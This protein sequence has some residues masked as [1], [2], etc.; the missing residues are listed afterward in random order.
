MKISGLLFA[1]LFILFA[2]CTDIAN[3]GS[4]SAINQITHPNILLYVVDDLGRNDIGCYGNPVVKT[5]AIDALAQ[6]GTRFTHAYCTTPSCSASRS[7][8]LT[9]QYNH[10]N[11][12]YGH[13]HFEFHFSALDRVKSLPV[14][15]DSIGYR[16][17]HV[18]K[19]HVAPLS[20]FRFDEHHPRKA[21]YP[22]DVWKPLDEYPFYPFAST[23]SPEQ[24]AEDMRPF[25]ADTTAAP[26]FLYFCTFEPHH[27]FK[28]AGSDSIGADQVIVPEHLPDIPQIREDLAKYYMSAQRADKGLLKLIE[29]L[30]ESGQWDNTVVLFISDNGR[31]FPGAKSNLY[32]PGILMPMILRNPFQEKKGIITDALVNYADITPT[33]LDFASVDIDKYHF[34]GRSFRSQ[35]NR[36]KS[37][38]FDTTFA[39]HTFHEIQMYYPMRMIRDR[40]YK[41]IW[42]LSWEQRF[43]LGV[44]TKGFVK[45]VQDNNLEYLGNRPISQYIRR[46]KYELYDLTGDPH[47]LHNLAEKNEYRDL[48]N[49]YKERLFSF[50]NRTDDFWKIYQEYDLMERIV[51]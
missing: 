34:H 7:V 26:F 35:L 36:E 29:I 13:S 31:P 51:E 45:L 32:D 27:P 42:N 10:A 22:E 28:R 1:Y 25:I 39:S 8:I 17:M 30:K 20:V 24:L 46:P 38:G 12:Q 23:R 50:Q 9:G 16:T 19:L 4:K 15:L 37:E 14:I 44:G 48:V 2:A 3:P 47:E 18:G 41:F 33:L 11:G 43:P 21:D 40:K 49:Y 5:P 6:E